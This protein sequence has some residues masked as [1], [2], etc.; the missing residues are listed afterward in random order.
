MTFP[1]PQAC[2]AKG[3]LPRGLPRPVEVIKEVQVEVIK[4]VQVEVEVI[5][6]RTGSSKVA[7]KIT[8]ISQMHH[9]S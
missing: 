1:L 2:S 4:E 3:L 6:V 9:G 5:K 7:M 8:K